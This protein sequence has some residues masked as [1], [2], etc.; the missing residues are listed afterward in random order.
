MK[1]DIMVAEYGQTPSIPMIAQEI[2]AIVGDERISVS[3]LEKIVENDPAISAKI[4]SLANS[5]FFGMTT[6]AKTLS[7]G[8]CPPR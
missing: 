1:N 4:L 2:L 3:K 7:N 5:A 6:P 8:S